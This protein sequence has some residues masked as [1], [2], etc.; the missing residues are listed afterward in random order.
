MNGVVFESIFLHRYGFLSCL[1]FNCFTSKL[2]ECL[3]SKSISWQRIL[4]SEVQ[5]SQCIMQESTRF[6]RL[7]TGSEVLEHSVAADRS[8]VTLPIEVNQEFKI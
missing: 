4:K 3:N 5:L 1:F 8:S 7:N 6:H 2:E